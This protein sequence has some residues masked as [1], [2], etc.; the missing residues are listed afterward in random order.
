MPSL[1]ITKD[2][3]QPLFGDWAKASKR[4]LGQIH[5]GEQLLA[6]FTGGGDFGDMVVATLSACITG[7]YSTW[8]RY[9]GEEADSFAQVVKVTNKGSENEADDER[10]TLIFGRAAKKFKIDVDYKELK[11]TGDQTPVEYVTGGD[12]VLEI[13]VREDSAPGKKKA[14]RMNVVIP[15]DYANFD[16]TYLKQMATD[17]ENIGATEDPDYLLSSLTFRRCL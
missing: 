16:E 3:D 13:V 1:L 2:V 6:S 14:K 12:G 15:S 4:Q 10:S 9:D 8:L 11:D 17:V 7:G 5:A